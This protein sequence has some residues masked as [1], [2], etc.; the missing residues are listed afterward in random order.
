M[1]VVYVLR[2][3]RNK[4]G[5]IGYTGKTAVERL[6]EHNNGS[7][8]FTSQNGP[9]KLIYTESYALKVE[10]IKRERFLKSGKGRE[11]LNN[12]GPLA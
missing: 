9:Y 10:A 4:K 11:F 12:I 8:K 7:N 2:S 1:F 6:T 5:Y 3:L